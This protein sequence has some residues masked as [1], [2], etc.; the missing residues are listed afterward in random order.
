MSKQLSL[1]A[2]LSVLATAFVAFVSTP[3]LWA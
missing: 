2:A 3:T 1:A